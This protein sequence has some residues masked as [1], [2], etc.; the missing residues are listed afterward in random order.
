MKRHKKCRGTG[1]RGRWRYNG[2]VHHSAR[3]GGKLISCIVVPDHSAN[4]IM[5]GMLGCEEAQTMVLLESA[6]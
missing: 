1:E 4:S 5:T 3:W 2:N 6:Y